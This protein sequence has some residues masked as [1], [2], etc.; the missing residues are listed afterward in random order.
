MFKID[1]AGTRRVFSFFISFLFFLTKKK[2]KRNPVV[3]MLLVFAIVHFY[4]LFINNLGLPS[5]LNASPVFWANLFRCLFYR[6]FGAAIYAFRVRAK[7]RFSASGLC[8]Y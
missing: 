7:S 2:R 8:E 6:Y 3:L 4:G 5:P 1:L